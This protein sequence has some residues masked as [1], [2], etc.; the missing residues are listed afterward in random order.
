MG[1]AITCDSKGSVSTTTSRR[2]SEEWFIIIQEQ[3]DP[4]ELHDQQHSSMITLVNCANGQ[5]LIS[6]W[7]GI[8]SSSSKPPS[9]GQE[10]WK[11]MRN[12]E[13]SIQK[14]SSSSTS[15]M[16]IHNS[17]YS[18]SST[19]F[20]RYLSKRVSKKSYMIDKGKT[21]TVGGDICTIQNP[22]SPMH[23][24]CFK[25][26]IISGEICFISSPWAQKQL[27]CSSWSFTGKPSTNISSS[28]SGNEV[29]RFIEVGDG[30]GTV[31]I[32]RWQDKS[33][34][35]SDASGKVYTVALSSL[36]QAQTQTQVNNDSRWMVDLAP[37]DPGCNGDY[38][39][40]VTFRSVSHNRYLQVGPKETISTSEYLTGSPTVW[41]IEAGNRQQFFISC[42]AHDKRLT[43]MDTA[44]KQKEESNGYLS[45]HWGTSEV[46][47]IHHH[48]HGGDHLVCLKSPKNCSKYH[49]EDSFN[50]LNSDQDGNVYAT[51]TLGENSM[52]I[53]ES[54]PNDLKNIAIVSKA[55]GRYLTC[56]NG[57]FYLWTNNLDEIGKDEAWCLQPVLPGMIVNQ[58][59]QSKFLSALGGSAVGMVLGPLAV[60][61]TI[62]AI[63]FGVGGIGAGSYAAWMMSLEGGATA[64]G[65]LV[66]TMQSIGAA[67][68][69]AT[70]VAASMTAGAVVGGSASTVAVEAVAG[71][72][73][74]Q[75]DDS[76]RGGTSIVGDSTNTT[77]SNRPFCNW[78]SW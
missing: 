74:K 5:Y 23:K 21:I 66:A 32:M 27:S 2:Q 50:F 9:E 10:L 14:Q 73:Q 24:W 18:I 25:I 12:S 55:S 16:P 77:L 4:Q 42:T 15:S 49:N 61:G 37:D 7:H 62:G 70:G 53:L 1:M 57:D 46:W 22:T 39:S 44:Q 11:L 17:Y 78:K 43:H 8:V 65:G 72:N 51:R 71:L 3:Q 54:I 34:L 6:D 60:M 68:L 64:A 28:W 75:L 63:G 40:G 31:R 29:W 67:G 35:A 52:W 48:D 47:E 56:R 38:P 30:N 45:P 58:N 19:K 36:G 13:K 76:S 20:G 41:Q 59:K 69:G 26:E 33:I